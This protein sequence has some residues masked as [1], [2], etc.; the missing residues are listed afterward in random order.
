MVKLYYGDIFVTEVLTNHS[1]SVDD[2]LE[3][4][5]IDLDGFCKQHGLEDIDFDLFEMVWEEDS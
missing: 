4:K 3:F 5:E 1:M 2:I